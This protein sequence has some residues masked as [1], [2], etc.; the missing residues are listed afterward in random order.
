MNAIA[1][2]CAVKKLR[3]VFCALAEI[4]HEFPSQEERVALYD[5]AQAIA[6]VGLKHDEA[7]GYQLFFSPNELDNERNTQ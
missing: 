1:T 6:K 7:G 2:A 5:A 4:I 3:D